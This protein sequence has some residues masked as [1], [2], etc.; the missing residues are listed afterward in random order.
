MICF[1]GKKS[2]NLLASSG[3]GR[4]DTA[5]WMQYLDAN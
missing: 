3:S 5:I 4:V 1:N 2:E